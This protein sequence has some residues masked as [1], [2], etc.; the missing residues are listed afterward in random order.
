MSPN[1]PTFLAH[2]QTLGYH[3]R[4]DKHS[5]SLA[6]AIIHDLF[7]H[8]P[9]IRQKALSG[10]L[11]YDINFTIR[12]A[13]ADW[14]VDLVIGTPH[15]DF[16]LPEGAT[17]IVRATPSTIQIAIEIKS[18]MTEHHKAIRNRKRDLEAH[19]DHVHRYNQHAIAGGVL[20]VNAASTFC[21][22]LRGIDIVTVHRDPAALVRLCIDQ[23]RAVAER[24]TV[25][26]TGLDA[27]AVIVVEMDN[28]HLSST[29]YLTK[30]PAPTVGDPLHYDAFIQTICNLYSE[31]FSN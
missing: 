30:S 11:V 29:C 18:V 28:Q 26:A 2:L 13:G 12:A 23:M 27:K 8:C 19:H 7:M 4:S 20:V 16:Q 24:H 6:E 22:P 3:P 17:D 21:S 15:L 31:R 10:Q 14:N 25:N 9:A 1:P 5:N